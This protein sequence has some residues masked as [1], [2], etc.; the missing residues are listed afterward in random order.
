MARVTK[1]MLEEDLIYVRSLN[2]QL[3][4]NL[5]LANKELKMTKDFIRLYQGTTSLTTA[6]E[7]MGD[8]LVHTIGFLKDI[9]RKG[10]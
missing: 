9:H 8:A 2:K 7:R 10:Y 6:N 1:A 5:D 3:R 4:N